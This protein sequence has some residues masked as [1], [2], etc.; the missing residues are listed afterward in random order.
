M[1]VGNLAVCLP[2]A[3]RIH[4]YLRRAG[5]EKLMLCPS[6]DD[7]GISDIPL[8]LAQPRL[9]VL[10]GQLWESFLGQI[11]IQDTDLCVIPDRWLEHIPSWERLQQVEFAIHLIEAHLSTP[12]QQYG[13][14]DPETLEVVRAMDYFWFERFRARAERSSRRAE[15]DPL[16]G[17]DDTR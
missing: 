6:F 9:V 13:A 7:S 2:D 11:L 8:L 1:K 10:V 14:K 16:Q 4:V 3:Q 5:Q 15:K 17:G 12:I